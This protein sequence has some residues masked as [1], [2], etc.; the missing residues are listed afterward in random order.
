MEEMSL[1]VDSRFSADE[2]KG[3]VDY[4]QFGRDDL[5]PFF[6]VY[7]SAKLCGNRTGFHYDEPGGKLLVWLNLG[8]IG[9]NPFRDG[10]ETDRLT[11][12]I[13]AYKHGT[14]EESANFRLDGDLRL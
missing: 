4:V 5:I 11:V 1:R 3:C 8:P 6:T 13:T 9:S 10:L 2:K 7:K 12:V 14:K